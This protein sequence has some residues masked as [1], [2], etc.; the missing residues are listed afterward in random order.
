MSGSGRI[1]TPPLGLGDAAPLVL[2][3][4]T[5][6]A[7][8]APFSTAMTA[9]DSVAYTVSRRLGPGGIKDAC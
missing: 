3:A 4:G 5:E 8:S 2:A 9:L 6:G 1:S 7:A